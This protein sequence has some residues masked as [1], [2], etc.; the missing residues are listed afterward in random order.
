VRPRGRWG[1]DQDEGDEEEE[2][3]E[4]E[5]ES[6][7]RGVVPIVCLLVYDCSRPRGGS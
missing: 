3:E 2:E 4:E 6:E 7:E 1:D 5:G